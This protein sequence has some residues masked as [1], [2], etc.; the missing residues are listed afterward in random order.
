MNSISGNL[1]RPAGIRI[2]HE[3]GD[4]GSL[5]AWLRASFKQQRD[6]SAHATM[7]DTPEQ[8]EDPR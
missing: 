5:A 7:T 2:N 6:S 4:D 8:Q 3:E 1:N